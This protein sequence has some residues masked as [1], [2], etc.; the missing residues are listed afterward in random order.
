VQ[1]ELKEKQGRLPVLSFSQRDEEIYS[2]GGWERTKG[3]KYLINWCRGGD[4]QRVFYVESGTHVIMFSF[5]KNSTVKVI[6]Y[7]TTTL[8]HLSVHGTAPPARH[9]AGQP[10]SSAEFLMHGAAHASQHA[11]PRPAVHVDCGAHSVALSAPDNHSCAFGEAD[12][13]ADETHAAGGVAAADWLT[14]TVRGW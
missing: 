12:V 11:P 7:A 6:A 8:L 2:L 13:V 10:M 1:R 14:A 9:Q 5:N 3:N 4:W